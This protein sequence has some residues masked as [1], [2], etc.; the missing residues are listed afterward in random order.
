MLLVD[1]VGGL[2][3]Q[4]F[5]Y[6]FGYSLSQRFQ[7]KVYFS[8]HMHDR[9]FQ[10]DVFPE[11]NISSTFLHVRKSKLE[12]IKFKLLRLFSYPLNEHF[13]FSWRYLINFP[14]Q[15]NVYLR[16][17]FHSEKYFE[18]HKKDLIKKLKFP[19][20]K[21]E[22]NILLASKIATHKESVSIH[23]RHGDYLLPQNFNFIGTLDFSYYEL[24]IKKIKEKLDNPHFFIFSENIEYIKEKF[25]FLNEENY[26]VV[27]H[28][29]G[30]DSYNDMALMTLCRHHII[31]NSSFSWWGAYLAESALIIAPKNWFKN[32]P[33]LDVTHILPDSW[34]SIDNAFLEEIPKLKD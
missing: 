18:M 22:K 24:A 20:F 1:I 7:T 19:P 23:V 21:E 5:I 16:G 9:S 13:G 29:T 4:L 28:N 26:T 3:N 11:V 12:K 15:K 14:S 2:G 25:A 8:V 34:L 17:Y 31:A 33:L 27:S 30:E 32:L 6:A 10:L